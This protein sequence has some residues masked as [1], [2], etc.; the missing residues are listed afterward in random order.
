MYNNRKA[1]VIYRSKTGFTKN[2]AQ[3]LAQDLNCELINGKKVKISDLQGYDTIIYGA[4]LYAAG[5]SGIKLITK[6]Y[7]QL[8]DKN[9]HVFAVGAT[10]VREET[11]E[12]LKNMNFTEEQR[13]KIHF[14]YLRGGFDYTRLSPL[15]RFLM[16]LK[17][18]QLKKVKNPDADVNGM[19]AS[20][21]HPLDFTKKKYI[22]PIVNEVMNS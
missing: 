6:N 11:T 12:E 22:E 2:Y 16:T 5:I 4:G 3:W 20:Y 14:Y 7:E 15:Y 8:K 19:L 10:P 1:V 9:L 13:K 18:L 17:K 21:D